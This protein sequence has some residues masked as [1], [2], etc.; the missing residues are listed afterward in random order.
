MKGPAAA[1]GKAGAGGKHANNVRRDWF[2]RLGKMDLDH[3][4]F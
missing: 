4:V 2:R 1:F 3:R